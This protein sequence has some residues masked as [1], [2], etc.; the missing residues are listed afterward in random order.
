MML[1]TTSACLVLICI[2]L[3]FHKPVGG[4][5]Y[6]FGGK[7]GV[8]KA[9]DTQEFPTGTALTSANK[10]SKLKCGDKVA[11]CMSEDSSKF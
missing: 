5:I 8:E 3:V 4:A 1:K 10:D 9:V 6:C 7:E 2:G 11:A